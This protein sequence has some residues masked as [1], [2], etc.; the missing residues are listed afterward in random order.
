MIMKKLFLFLGVCS[1]FSLSGM[2]RISKVS[3]AVLRS[4]QVRKV[5]VDQIS[6]S[7]FTNLQDYFHNLKK[8]NA[9]LLNAAVMCSEEAENLRKNIERFEKAKF[10]RDELFFQYIQLASCHPSE[11]M[12]PRLMHDVQ[13]RLRAIEG[14]EVMRAEKA[15]EYYRHCEQP[16]N[17]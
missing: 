7:Y 6:G 13:S 9:T 12:P 2:H 14:N 15:A 17:S 3:L 16:Q 5:S 11:K 1:A 8:A 4:L 10:H